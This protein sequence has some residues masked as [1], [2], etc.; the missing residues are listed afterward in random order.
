V[1]TNSHFLRVSQCPRSSLHVRGTPG[2]SRP[3]CVQDLPRDAP[4]KKTKQKNASFDERNCFHH[5]PGHL[6]SRWHRRSHD[7]ASRQMTPCSTEQHHPVARLCHRHVVWVAP[8]GTRGSQ[9]TAPAA[10]RSADKKHSLLSKK[11]NCCCCVGNTHFFQK[12]KKS[13]SVQVRREFCCC[14]V[15]LSE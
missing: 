13:A 3:T 15:G 8:E 5:R 9:A 14:C 11:K 6:P 10:R 1:E 12:K 4:P 2:Q 7:T